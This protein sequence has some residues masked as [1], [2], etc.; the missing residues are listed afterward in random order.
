MIVKNE[1]RIIVRCL[2][3]V[4]HIVDYVSICDTGSTDSTPDIIKTWCT[5]HEIPGTVHSEPFK[6]FGYNRTLSVELAKKTYPNATYFL[7]LDADM[8][9]EVNAD[10]DKQSLDADSYL[11]LQYNLAIEYWNTRLVKSSHPWKCVGCTHEYWDSCRNVKNTKLKTLKIDDREDGGAKADK[12]T[13]DY[14]LLSDGIQDPL[15]PHHLRCRYFF[16]IAQTCRDLGKYDESIRWY[17]KRISAGGWAEEIF[18]SHFQ[19]GVC[20]EKMLST[21]PDEKKDVCTAMIIKSYQDAWKARPE[22]A[23]SLAALAKFHRLRQEYHLALMYAETGKRISFPTD[24][25]L[26]IDYNVYN[27]LFDFEISISAYYV[28]GKKHLGKEATERLKS[29]TGLP[30]YITSLVE[31]N[32]KFYS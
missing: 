11:V 13:R 2:N 19:I 21:V 16:Y 15:T 29:M 9:L 17:R 30:K 4:K 1:S 10:F 27:Y 24:D 5:K 22:R 31:S 8:I 32:S 3:S 23:E 6:N 7:L 18:Y 25:T 20:Y 26:F 28:P 14:K 12:F